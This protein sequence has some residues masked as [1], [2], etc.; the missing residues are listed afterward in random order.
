M[1]SKNK[2]GT[3]LTHK[4]QKEKEYGTRFTELMRLPYFNC[5]RFHIITPMHNLFTGTAKHI[6]NNIWFDNTSTVINKNQL[7]IVHSSSEILGGGVGINCNGMFH[8]GFNIQK[9]IDNVCV[10]S[11]VGRLPKTIANSYGG[12]TADQWK[13]WTIIYSIFVMW[14]ILPQKHLEVCLILIDNH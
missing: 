3:S 11:S 13:S 10:P 12:F 5:I 8:E 7:I 6:M 1:S 4:Q 9:K 2:R 14:D